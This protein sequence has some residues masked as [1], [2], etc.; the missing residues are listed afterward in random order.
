MELFDRPDLIKE[1]CKGINNIMIGLTEH[2]H[3][4]LRRL[5]H[6]Q[7]SSW[8]QCTC[9]G[10]F[11]AV[12]VDFA[13]MISPD[14]FREFA[15]EDLQEFVSHLDHAIYHLDGTGQLR[16]LDILAEV[17]GLDGIQ[18][19]PEPPAQDPLKWLDTFRDIRKRGWLLY[20]N[21][22]ECRTVEHAVAIVRSVGPDGLFL[23]L[24]TFATAG[25][26]EDA[27]AAI[28]KASC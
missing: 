12:Q 14:Q 17:R 21:E 24:P 6:G 4:L 25:E 3:A 22:W 15:L 27:I 8:F 11:E 23:T 7:S 9:E 5:G 10:K 20:F 13:A 18:W 2:Y 1:W 19:N 16:F 28:E 26:A